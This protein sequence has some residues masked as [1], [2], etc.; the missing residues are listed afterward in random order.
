MGKN[1]D[2]FS[3]FHAY[4]KFKSV[5]G[6]CKDIGDTVPL[7]KQWKSALQFEVHSCGSNGPWNVVFLCDIY[8]KRFLFFDSATQHCVAF[9]PESAVDQDLL[10][11]TPY[12][13]KFSSQLVWT[14]KFRFE[15]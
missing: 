9:V 4:D 5:V 15:L 2:T 12:V 11:F 13:V 14:D 7:K 3:K 8:H 1:T 6:V 10:H